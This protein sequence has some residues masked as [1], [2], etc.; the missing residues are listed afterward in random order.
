MSAPAIKPYVRHPSDALLM[1]TVRH[2]TATET[3]A[4][5]TAQGYV[6]SRSACERLRSRV[7]KEMG[8]QRPP[9]ARTEAFNTNPART[10]ARDCDRLEQALCDLYAKTAKRLGCRLETAALYLN[11]TPAQIAKMQVAA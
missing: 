6:V 10:A 9:R 11:Y 1:E 5:L 3:Y 7:V 2:H 8:W 4:I